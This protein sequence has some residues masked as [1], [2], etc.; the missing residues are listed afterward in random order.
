VV[1]LKAV[2]IWF[3]RG[4]T[5]QLPLLNHDNGLL[6]DRISDPL[7]ANPRELTAF[8]DEPAASNTFLIPG[9]YREYH[10]I[11]EASLPV[12]IVNPAAGRKLRRNEAAA[13][14]ANAQVRTDQVPVSER[15][16]AL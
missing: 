9:R 7:P 1:R 6:P 15:F 11:N 16:G 12:I 4:L 13:I 10:E 8:P 3:A 2:N 14:T 5:G